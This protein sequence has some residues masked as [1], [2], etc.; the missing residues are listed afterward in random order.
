MYDR[1]VDEVFVWGLCYPDLLRSFMAMHKLMG[2]D[3][4]CNSYSFPRQTER[5][6]FRANLPHA[7]WL[8]RCVLD[9]KFEYTK[10]YQGWKGHNRKHLQEFLMCAATC[11]KSQSTRC[12]IY[13]NFHSNTDISCIILSQLDFGRFLLFVCL[14]NYHQ[15][16]VCNAA[17]YFPNAHKEGI[18]LP[19]LFPGGGPRWSAEGVSRI[20]VPPKWAFYRRSHFCGVVIM[21][22][23][24]DILS[25]ILIF[26]LG[27]YG[28]F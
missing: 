10:G 25:F 11:T 3:A 23:A 24:A 16:L 28:C 9:I 15:A 2:F 12:D 26:F 19:G 1:L 4:I 8:S 6:E 17:V 20:F 7:I 22:C 21:E 14:K 18:I 13:I 27:C 5:E